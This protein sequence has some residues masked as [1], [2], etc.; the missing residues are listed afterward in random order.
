MGHTLERV[1]L[2]CPVYYKAHWLWA[3]LLPE[4]L[5]GIILDPLVSHTGENGHKEIFRKIWFWR[6]TVVVNDSAP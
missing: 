6:E 4:E 3:L 2:C 1:R 5:V